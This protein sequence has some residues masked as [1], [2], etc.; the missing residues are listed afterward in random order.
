ML[1]NIMAT[2]TETLAELGHKRDIVL[3]DIF[4]KPYRSYSNRCFKYEM[5]KLGPDELPF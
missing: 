2:I 1:K 4:Y 5:S 3:R